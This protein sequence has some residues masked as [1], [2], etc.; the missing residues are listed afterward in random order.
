MLRERE[1]EA[2]AGT[3]RCS[4]ETNFDINLR[5]ASG[6]KVGRAIRAADLFIRAIFLSGLNKLRSPYLFL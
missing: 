5:K 4:I 1:G 6:S 2:H 3:K